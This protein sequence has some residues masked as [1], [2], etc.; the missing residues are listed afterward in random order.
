MSGV[1]S[2]AARRKGCTAS[3]APT[4]QE[5]RPC[6]HG[7]VDSRHAGPG[8]T[9]QAMNVFYSRL[10]PPG[11]KGFSQSIFICSTLCLLIVCPS[12]NAVGRD[13]EEEW[14]SVGNKHVEGNKGQLSVKV[15]R[16]ISVFLKRSYNHL[17]VESD[18]RVIE[19]PPQRLIM[20]TS[21]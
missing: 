16:R 18:G 9:R 13:E 7:Q 10:T 12:Q 19:I 15:H 1:S 8:C 21:H 3:K 5:Q 17:C 2:W 20:D 6:V 14:S 11:G 4:N